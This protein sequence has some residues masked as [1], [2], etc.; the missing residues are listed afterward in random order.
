VADETPASQD[1]SNQIA[2]VEPEQTAP[3]ETQHVTAN[4]NNDVFFG[5][6]HLHTA[7]S[8]DAF[9]TNTR[10]MPDDAYR[11]AKGEAINHVSGDKVQIRT[12]LDFMG[13]TDHAELLGVANAMGDPENPLSQ[14]ELA[15][16]ITSVDYAQ[17]HRA[18]QTILAAGEEGDI[19]ELIDIQSAIAATQSAWQRVIDAAE[20]HNEPGKFTT[21]IAYEWSSM[22]N[23]SNLHRNIVYEG[24]RAPQM[25]FSS[26]VSNKPED[27][28]KHLDEWRKTGGDVIAIPHNS[29]ASKGLMY[30]LKDSFGNPVDMAYAETR[31]RNEPITEITQFKGT[32]ETHP[33]LAPLDEF[34]DFEIWNN[35]VGGTA[36]VEPVPG[37]YVRNAYQRGLALED[38]IGSNPYR[39]GLIGSSDSHD[40]STAVEEFNFTGGHGNADATPEIRLNSKASTLTT[41]SLNFSAS[42]LAA[43]WA[44]SNTRAAIFAALRRKET[45][46]TSGTR[47]KLRFFGGADLSD[48]SQSGAVEDG[49]QAGV[50]MGGDLNLSGEEAPEFFVWAMRDVQSAGLDRVQIIKGWVNDAGEGVEEIFDVACSIGEPNPVSKRCPDSGGTVDLATCAY[51][52]AGV[53]ELS[54][55]WKDPSYVEDQSAVYYVRVLENPT[56]R[57][58]TW[59][60][61]RIGQALPADVPATIRERA[62][63]S[64]IWV[65]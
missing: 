37:S 46:G 24:G 38:S 41:S 58:S 60:A 64:P 56:C 61:V 63:S 53:G 26:G 12:P 40:S 7:L 28:W 30:P 2:N 31:M 17:S 62:W 54:G 3:A 15:K 50:P 36:V 19:T 9:I 21:F 11:Y 52:D 23:M 4:P 18:F 13:V 27:L 5:D 44:E 14:S 43:V 39:F 42:G 6:L 59:D 29:N 35:V 49:Y 47:I 16:D 51:N 48:I 55:A 1:T 8:V 20:A 10:T 33:A 22:P 32:S 25:P 34:A 65:N 57:W 45:Y